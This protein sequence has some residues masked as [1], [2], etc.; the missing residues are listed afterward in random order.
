MKKNRMIF[1]YV[2]LL[3]NVLKKIKTVYFKS[4]RVLARAEK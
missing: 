2:E 1:S 4:Q 3:E